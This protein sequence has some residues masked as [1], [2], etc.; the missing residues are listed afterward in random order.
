[1][2]YLAWSAIALAVLVAALNAWMTWQRL[3]GASRRPAEL[4]D[5]EEYASG[6]RSKGEHDEPLSVLGELD[7]RGYTSRRRLRMG[8]EAAICRTP[9]GARIVAGKSGL[10]EPQYAW[11]YPSVAR[12]HKALKYAKF[13]T[14]RNEGIVVEGFGSTF[15]PAA[16][17]RDYS[18]RWRYTADRQMRRF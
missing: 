8:C 18:R 5:L 2:T 7:E 3:A 6:R 14:N 4:E 17:P 9:F 11:D 10:E 13:R 15:Y 16:E 1:M 12:A